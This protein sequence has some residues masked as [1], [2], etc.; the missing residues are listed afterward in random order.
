MNTKQKFAE[1]N[2]I[3][4]KLG[5]KVLKAWKESAAKLDLA[6]MTAQRALSGKVD[7]PPTVEPSNEKLQK[8]FNDATA[9]VK[10]TAKVVKDK[11][12][13]K[14]DGVTLMEIAKAL[15]M[16]DKVARAKLR[17]LGDKVPTG[18][19]EHRWVFKEGDVMKVRQLLGAD[20]RVK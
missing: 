11:A 3:R 20:G 18:L 9:P 17:R 1:L 7:T 16:D 13:A 2:A 10:S 14:V 8:A 15:G 12:P 19:G 4:E 6:L 5:M